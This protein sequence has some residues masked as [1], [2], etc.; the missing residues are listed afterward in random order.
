MTD[1][2]ESEGTRFPL[3]HCITLSSFE[4]K[5]FRPHH[6]IKESRASRLQIS[7]EMLQLFNKWFRINPDDTLVRVI[8][9]YNH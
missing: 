6:P 2:N 7:V 1:Q 5:H 4:Q 9:R 3:I 8:K